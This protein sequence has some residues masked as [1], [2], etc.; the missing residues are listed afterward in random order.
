MRT[1][2][3]LGIIFT[4]LSLSARA[5]ILFDFQQLTD[6]KQGEIRGIL[7]D[8]TQFPLGNPYELAFSSFTWTIDNLSLDVSASYQGSGKYSKGYKDVYKKYDRLNGWAYLDAGNAG[9]GVCS[10]GLKKDRKGDFQCDPGSD[11]N[12]TVDEWLN[13]NFDN[14]VALNFNNSF[15][16]NAGHHP[17]NFETQSIEVSTDSGWTWLNLE[18]SSV[19]FGQDF[20]FRTGTDKS[21]FYI[22]T[23]AAVVLTPQNIQDVDDANTS[24][25]T[26][27]LLSLAGLSLYRRK[28]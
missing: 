28:R 19:L 5:D 11:D 4:T 25:I 9:L 21:Q 17:F 7:P 3:L 2:L 24:L 12:V 23:I 26:L 18:P 14:Y 16:R 8:K 20:T 1:S 10:K 27:F 22:D 13:F 15:F 6:T